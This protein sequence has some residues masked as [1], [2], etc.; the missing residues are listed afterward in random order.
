MAVFNALPD[1]GP[2][3]VFLS[4]GLDS[5]TIAYYA[6]Q[7]T[8]VKTFTIG[9]E[10]DT[11]GEQHKATQVAKLLG[12]QHTSMLFDKQLFIK[13][14]FQ[15]IPKLDEP[16]ADSS[17]IPE[18]YIATTAKMEV[19]T[20]LGGDGGDEL[21]CGYPIFRAHDLLRVYR[22]IPRA[23]RRLFEVGVNLIPTPHTNENWT[24]RAKKFIEAEGHL[25][26]P[27][28][29]QAIWWG[30]F[31]P[32]R[33]VRLFKR[34]IDLSHLFDPIRFIRAQSQA[35]E[36]ETDMLLRQ[37]QMKYLSGDKVKLGIVAKHTG[38]DL[39]APFLDEEVVKYANKLPF[40]LKYRKGITKIILKEL[41]KD[42]LPDDI[43]WGKKRGF[44]PP[45][46]QWITDPRIKDIIFIRDNLFNQSYIKQL[47][48][49]HVSRRQ[50]H[51]KLLWTLF[52]WKLWIRHN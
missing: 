36:T 49:E 10:E 17:L 50:N 48:E 20:V 24:Y 47:W 3:G 12:T 46:A 52:V 18:C 51:R 30:A 2:V 33:L 16:F 44:T 7:H 8:K 14:A 27:Y 40:N 28:L 15:L 39:R 4:G 1:D 43:V 21:F 9:F 32:A 26:N 31:N 42:K 11:Y 6:S 23:L 22:H 25:D 5:A 37:T 29:C 19:N 41:M 34:P 45:I 13:V 38:L 35:G